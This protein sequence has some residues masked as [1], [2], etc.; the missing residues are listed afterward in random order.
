MF[1]FSLRALLV[2][3]V[4][5]AVGCAALTHP[6]KAWCNAIV[7]LMFFSLLLATVAAI[8]GKGRVRTSAGG[9]AIAAWLYFIVVFSSFFTL[10]DRLLTT[11][12]LEPLER[13]MARV[14]EE[15][16]NSP[17]LAMTPEEFVGIPGLIIRHF[18]VIGQALWTLLVGISG[19][20]LAVWFSRR[21]GAKS[22][23][24]E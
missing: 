22:S 17:R 15:S 13:F 18:H 11:Q 21:S 3:G 2:L 12:A 5:V 8:F 14:S 23:G 20:F 24:G 1:Q 6:T 7:T 4:L 10:E 9:F 16:V 19:S